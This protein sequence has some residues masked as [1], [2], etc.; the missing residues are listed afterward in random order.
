MDQKRHE[1]HNGHHD[2]PTGAERVR[3]GFDRRRNWGD[4]IENVYRRIDQRL[5]EL[6]QQGSEKTVAL[7]HQAE[8]YTARHPGRVL[9]TIFAAG[10]VLGFFLGRESDA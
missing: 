5:H 8:D 9:A 3:S 4:S 7:E 1:A 10:L 6:V 2:A